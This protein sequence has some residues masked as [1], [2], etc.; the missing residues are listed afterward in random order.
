[1][2]VKTKTKVSGRTYFRAMSELNYMRKALFGIHGYTGREGYITMRLNE[3]GEA[4]RNLR[5]LLL[6][7]LDPDDAARNEKWLRED[8]FLWRKKK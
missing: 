2:V 4:M 1:M 6:S 3:A 5:N 8:A 7:R